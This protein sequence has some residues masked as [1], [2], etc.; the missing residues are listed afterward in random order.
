MKEAGAV[1]LP[2]AGYCTSARAYG[3][4][5]TYGYYWSSTPNAST[6]AYRMRFYVDAVTPSNSEG[7]ATG[8]S[9]R[10]VKNYTP[11]K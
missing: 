10:L 4:E 9:V 3:Q 6:T 5:G 2:A 1:F 7:R 11:S 8:C